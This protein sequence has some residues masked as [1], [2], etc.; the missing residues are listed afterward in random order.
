MTEQ[1]T[2]TTYGMAR[3]HIPEGT[4]S[5]EELEKM[6]KDFEYI[7]RIQRQHLKKSLGILNKAAEDNGEEL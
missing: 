5:L 1:Y 2:Y 6:V 3:M 4:Y 7:I